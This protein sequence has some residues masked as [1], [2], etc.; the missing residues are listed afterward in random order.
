[1]ANSGVVKEMKYFVAFLWLSPVL[2]GLIVGG[3][4]YFTPD[5]PTEYAVA[6]GKLMEDEKIWVL[7]RTYVYCGK[8]ELF[9]DDTGHVHKTSNNPIEFSS[10]DRCY[11]SSKVTDL[12]K[13]CNLYQLERIKALK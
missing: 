6:L 10:S 13:R 9:V 2:F 7:G 4:W 5:P 12:R 3:A 8:H 11:L 1:L